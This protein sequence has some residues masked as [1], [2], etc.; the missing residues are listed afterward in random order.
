MY[1]SDLSIRR[2]V[3]AWVFTILILIAGIIGY[4]ALSVRELPDVDVPVVTVTVDWRGAAPDV[5]ETEVTDLIE[6]EVNTV[7]GIKTITSQTRE[8]RAQITVEFELEVNVDVAAQDVRDA[9]ARVRRRLPDDIDPPT[10]VKLDI[11]A[12]PI[13]WVSVNSE[14][15]TR[16]ELADFV[17]RQLS[18]RIQVLPGVGRVQA[19]GSQRFA[20][21]VEL[22]VARLTAHDL[23][24]TDVAQALQRENIELPSGRIESQLREF[25]VRTQGRI[26]QPEDF[27]DIVIVSRDGV[28]IRVRDV[29]EVVRGT[30]NERNLARFIQTPTIGMGILRQSQAN[31]LEVTTRVMEELDRIRPELPPPVNLQVAFDG[32]RFI[33]ESVRSTERTLMLAAVLVVIVIFVF[34]RSLR[35]SFIPAIVI[36]VA[37]MGTFA[38]MNALSFSINV[39][40]LLGLILAIGL[41]VDDAVVMLENIYRHMEQEHED[42]IEAARNGA[43]EIGFAVIA[44]SISLA[45]VFVPVAFVTGTIG[46]FFYEFGLTVASAIFISTFIALTLTPMLSSRLIR[47]KKRHMK[48]YHLLESGFDAIGRSYK[49]WLERALR[50]RVITVILAIGTFAAGIIM[51]RMLPGEF[52]PQQDQGSLIAFFRG[53]EGSTL[54]YMD[55]YLKE[56]E[57][58]ADDIPEIRTYMGILGFGANPPNRGIMFMTLEERDQRERDQFEIMAEMRR[59]TAGIPGIMVFLRERSPFGGRQDT[60]PVQFVIQH[61]DLEV[62]A[63]GSEELVRQLRDADGFL[64]VDSDLDLN[65]PELMVHIDRER[66]SLLGISVADISQALQLMLGGVDVTDY[67][68]RGKQYNVIARLREED[69]AQP[70]N[71]DQV[72]LRGHSGDLVPLSNIAR[73]EE[74]VGPSQINHFNRVRSVTVA[75]NLEGLALSD[76]LEKVRELADD[77]FPAETTYELTGTARDLEESFQALTFTLILAIVVVFLVLAAQ[78]NS[79]IHPFT[80]MLGLPLAL[81]GAFGG[82]LLAGQSLN[83]FSFIGLI[84]LTGL[85]TKNGILLIDYTNRLRDRGVERYEAVVTAG[86]VRLRPILMTAVTTIFGVLPIALGLGAGGEARA[87]LGVVVIGGMTVS[88]ILT[89]VVVPVIYTLLDDLMNKLK[90]RI[91]RTESAS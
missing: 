64:D 31:T 14:W 7:E 80:I 66:A 10:V 17:D 24:V 41:L 70:R 8:E 40:T 91:G 57:A 13:M 65:K 21:R 1:L 88:T 12:Q 38:I 26:T 9:V 34:L 60:R 71:L 87:P 44:S 51:A 5:M 55:R 20:V 15:M 30:E 79:W 39:I 37:V 83:I 54:E 25:V 89:L 81:V 11:D 74:D 32:S 86:K 67:Q 78:F 35:S 75:A 27:Q 42:P 59:R 85:V 90:G 77:I 18:D 29:A 72:Y 2:P 23:T 58:I 3:L 73:F 52:T 56:V 4:N 76:A 45:A 61:P 53:P 33:A 62:L 50:H 43:S 48:I 82:L 49:R 28:P 16:T 36:P 22:D 19:G 6:E 47:V 46:V 69:R 84:M 68:E 63:E